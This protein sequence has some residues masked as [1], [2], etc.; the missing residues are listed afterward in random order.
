M[1]KFSSL[2]RST[3]KT[4]WA[5][6]ISQAVDAAISALGGGASGLLTELDILE[7]Q[8]TG[9][10]QTVTLGDDIILQGTLFSQGSIGY[11]PN[12]G[13]YTLGI[14]K[15]YE[16]AAYLHL[17]NYTAEEVTVNWVQADTNAFI[18]ES[19][20]GIYVADDG[21]SSSASNPGPH[22]VY[23]PTTAAEARVK[24]R[25]VSSAGNADVQSFAS[26][27]II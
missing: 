21:T 3:D 15:T 26:G 22:M 17:I 2:W 19:L 12:T 5:Q 24:L 25:V 16:L 14:G 20:L 13:I 9:A 18:D 10:V 8:R 1:G 11:D 27:A 4:R 23:K 7:T 6:Q